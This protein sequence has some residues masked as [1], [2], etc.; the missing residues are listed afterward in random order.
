MSKVDIAGV[1]VD[2]ITKNETLSAIKGFLN[3]GKKHYIVT[4]YSEQIVFALKDEEYRRVLN[5]ADLALPDG[6][7]I[8]WAAKFLNEKGI[9][10]TFIATLFEIILSPASIRTVIPQQITGRHLVYDLVKIAQEKN[11]SLALVGGEE[12][13]AAQAAYEL[14]KNFGNLKINLALSGRPFDE[15]IIKEIAESNSDIL[16][17]A[18]SPPKQEKW[19]AHNLSKLNVKLA[20]G[21]GGTFDYIAKKRPTAPK[22]VHYMGLEWLW[23]LTTQPWRAKRIWN[24]VPVFS[25]KVLNYKRNVTRSKN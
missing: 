7:G 24:A 16:L 14:K 21:L 13:V 5:N 20:I 17:I 6:I 3:D 22:F 10:F 4:P 15:Q 12:N 19:M 18:Y 1:Y 11:Y 8:L 23:R 2:A 9:Y 25:F